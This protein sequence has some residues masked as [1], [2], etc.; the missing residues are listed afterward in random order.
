MIV[1]CYPLMV[2]SNLIQVPLC[3]TRVVFY[4]L[5]KPWSNLIQQNSKLYVMKNL[6]LKYPCLKQFNYRPPM[7]YHLQP[8]FPSKTL[9]RPESRSVGLFHY[10]QHHVVSVMIMS[11]QWWLSSRIWIKT[12][13]NYGTLLGK[14]GKKLLLYMKTVTRRNTCVNMA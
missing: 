9:W 10:H 11:C 5:P 1:S 4:Y 14:L 7:F 12:S 3:G 8:G 6:I 13:K 2:W